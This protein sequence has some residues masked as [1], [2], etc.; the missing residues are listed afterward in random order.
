MDGP[1]LVGLTIQGNGSVPGVVSYRFVRQE[2]HICHSRH[3][4]SA[5]LYLYG[6]NSY[7]PDKYVDL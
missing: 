4:Q 6:T 3:R 1:E 2:G 5:D 7:I